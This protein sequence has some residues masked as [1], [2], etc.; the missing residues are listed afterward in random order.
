[1]NKKYNICL[2]VLVFASISFISVYS[3]IYKQEASRS[4]PP[5]YN[6]NPETV[7]GAN[8]IDDI[9]DQIINIWE[10]PK[11]AVDYRFKIS[12]TDDLQNERTTI[13]LRFYEENSYILSAQVNAQTGQILSIA[14]HRYYGTCNKV[15][16]IDQVLSVSI[17]VIEK[18]GL[19]VVNLPPPTMNEPIQNSESNKM[20][21]VKW[22]QYYKGV[23]VDNGLIK[24]IVDAEYLQ[25]IV[26]SNGL[27]EVGDIDVSP[28]V[29]EAQAI[30]A[31]REYLKTG[32]LAN[33]GYS[34]VKIGCVRLCITRPDCDPYNN[35]VY[36]PIHDPCLAWRVDC[37]DKAGRLASIFIDANNGEAVSITETL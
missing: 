28:Q 4:Q 31:V 25:P 8:S 36:V 26:F 5:I 29:S 32:V 6:I 15:K 30:D 34:Q 24:V 11:A 33:K 7:T 3:S 2:I 19:N 20:Y 35:R 22:R 37:T 18:M 10:L 12:A 13:T 27:K 9:K 1:M 16:S 21:T 17:N 14:D 23:P